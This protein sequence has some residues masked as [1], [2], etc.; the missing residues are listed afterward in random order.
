LENKKIN[1][2]GKKMVRYWLNIRLNPDNIDVT[3]K[4]AI[5]NEFLIE[6]QIAQQIYKINLGFEL[7]D[8]LTLVF[9][10]TDKEQIKKV[11]KEIKPRLQEVID[12]PDIGFNN[13][14][15]FVSITTQPE[16]PKCGNY[17]RFSDFHCSQCGSELSE[18]EFIDLE[19]LE[20]NQY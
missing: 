6:T 20:K 13:F 15:E 10:T 1:E 5:K 2:G 7:T 18:K 4:D 9:K 19:D 11:I 8:D 17:G 16:C 14:Y 12:S 3:D